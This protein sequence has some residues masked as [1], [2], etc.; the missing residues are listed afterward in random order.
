MGIDASI[1][2]NTAINLNSG[3]I[4]KYLIEEQKKSSFSPQVFF[5]LLLSHTKKISISK[6]IEYLN[7]KVLELTYDLKIFDE[8]VAPTLSDLNREYNR[9][10]KTKKL[11]EAK[12]KATNYELFDEIVNHL[13]E[14]SISGSGAN[15]NADSIDEGQDGEKPPFENN[16]N[17]MPI[18]QVRL[19]FTP[20]LETENNSGKKWMAPESFDIFLRRSFVKEKSL[21]RPEINLGKGTKGAIVKLFYQFY[22]HCIE[23]NHSSKREKKPY[24]NLLMD[25]FNTGIFDNLNDDSFN[26]KADWDWPDFKAKLKS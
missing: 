21:Q 19:F 7:G 20:L 3:T 26:G 12:A 8:E 1:I 23:K 22:S 24:V 9:T 14:Q 4:K 17:R 18:D 6:E 16:F 10:K 13:L 11:E 15:P 25:A 2:F 5:D